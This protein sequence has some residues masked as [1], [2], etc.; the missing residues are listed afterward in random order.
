VV[1]DKS[2]IPEWSNGVG[3][4]I[5]A[6]GGGNIAD[7][8]SVVGTG[9]MQD[10][11]LELIS[12]TFNTTK[13]VMGATE[14]ALGDE[15]AQNTSAILA[16]Q[17]T[18]R[19]PLYQVRS[20]LHKCI[21]ELANIWADMMFAYYP[22]ERLFI[23]VKDGEPSAY[24]MDLSLL[25]NLLPSAKVDIAEISRYNASTAQT[26]LDKLLERGHITPVEYLRRIPAGLIPEKDELIESILQRE[27]KG[28]SAYE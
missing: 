4:A 11:Y 27:N 6:V 3:E 28:E 19:I 18:S 15:K 20:A 23:T 16:L 8:V 25:K 7:A 17:E 2:R 12:D 14:S 9:R 5:A 24:T 10:H 13:D 26:L 1:Y 22:A 21:E